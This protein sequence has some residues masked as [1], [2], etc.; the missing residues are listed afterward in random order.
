[1]LGALRVVEEELASKLPVTLV[2]VEELTDE[3]VSV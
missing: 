1:M 2:P 3:N